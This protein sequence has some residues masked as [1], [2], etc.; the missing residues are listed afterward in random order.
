MNNHEPKVILKEVFGFN[1]F[2]EGQEKVI[3][4]LLSGNSTLAVFPTGSGK[5]LCYQIPAILFEGLTL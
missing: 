4:S 1:E 2:R 3:N 5:S